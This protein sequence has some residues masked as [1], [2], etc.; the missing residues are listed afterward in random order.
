[1]HWLDLT[2]KCWRTANPIHRYCFRPPNP[3]PKAS[4][5]AASWLHF[6]FATVVRVYCERQPHEFVEIELILHR[7]C[8][9]HWNSLRRHLALVANPFL[10]AE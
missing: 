3:N 5:L 4:I 7:L 2:Q 6:A 8:C 10:S 1:M 9:F